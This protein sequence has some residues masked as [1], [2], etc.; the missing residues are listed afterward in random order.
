MFVF[1]LNVYGI[2]WTFRMFILLFIKIHYLR[3]H[4][5]NHCLTSH[6]ICFNDSL[7]KY[8]KLSSNP[9]IFQS[10]LFKKIIYRCLIL[11]KKVESI[12][13]KVN[14]K[15]ISFWKLFVMMSCKLTLWFWLQNNSV[16]FSYHEKLVFYT[17]FL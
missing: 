1:Y 13:L 5:L 3:Q 6:N 9:H 10:F 17:T 16:D 12:Y 2:E 4:Q 14:I 11:A 15:N 7:K 8:L